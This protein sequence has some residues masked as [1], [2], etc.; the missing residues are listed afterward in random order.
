MKILAIY[1][2]LVTN[3]S[4]AQNIEAPADSYG[5]YNSEGSYNTGSSNNYESPAVD[6]G[7]VN[8]TSDEAAENPSMEEPASDE[9]YE[10]QE[11]DQSPE[12]VNPTL[13]S[14]PSIGIIEDPNEFS[15]V[16]VGPGSLRT[17]AESEAPE[18]YNVENGDSLF[19]ICDQLLD[20]PYYWPKLWALNPYITNPH[21]IYPGMKLKFYPGD[22]SNPPFLKVVTEDDII[23]VNDLQKEEI[24]SQDV[25]GMLLKEDL[26]GQIPVV[27]PS[28]VAD[29]PEISDSF[30]TVGSIYNEKSVEVMV[31][32][33]YYKEKIEP[34]G[35]VVSG[36]SGELLAEDKM[37]VIVDSDQMSSGENYTVVRSA[38]NGRI[39]TINSGYRY[40]FVAQIKVMSTLEGDLKKAQVLLSRLGVQSGDIVIP[41]KDVTRRIPTSEVKSGGGDGSRVVGF[42]YPYGQVGGKGSILFLQGDSQP[43]EGSYVRLYQ[44][45][46]NVNPVIDADELPFAQRYVA[47]AYTF[48]TG[49]NATAAY[50]VYS[51]DAILIGNTSGQVQSADDASATNSSATNSSDT[52]EESSEQSE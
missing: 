18:E 43:S 28:G 11:N 3:H 27:G 38:E 33:F 40:E 39:E 24:I 4:Y 13:D 23:P 46:N 19:D 21:F 31:P 50:V 25:S 37:Q 49:D 52:N 6:N 9:V 2:M 15:G 36:T 42:E 32:A 7:A 10:P 14:S 44:N 17:L 41:Y 22:E 1:L 8:F 45:L 48:Y 20:E 12:G 35:E 34:K 16:P 51:D 47:T 29:F 26:P 30:I 5:N